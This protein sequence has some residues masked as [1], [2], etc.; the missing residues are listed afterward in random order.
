MYQVKKKPIQNRLETRVS[1]G[2]CFGFSSLFL[3]F[4]F[5]GFE[6]GGEVDLLATGRQI[7]EGVLQKKESIA[8]YALASKRRSLRG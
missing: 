6:V 3:D 1:G 2:F 4:V 5:F 7:S 8:R